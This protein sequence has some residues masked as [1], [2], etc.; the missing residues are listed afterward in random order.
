MLSR[1]AMSQSIDPHLDTRATH[2]VFEGIDPVSIDFS[3]PDPHFKS[4][5]HKLQ[6]SS[7]LTHPRPLLNRCALVL[8]LLLCTTATIPATA[9]DGGAW[10][11]SGSIALELRWFPEDPALPDQFEGTQPSAVLEPELRWR[12][13]DRRHQIDLAGFGRL[14]GRD[15][16]RSHLDLREASYRYIGDSFE[17]LA[18]VS[19]VFWGVTEARHLVDTLN[20]IDGVEDIDE[21]DRLGQ[22]MV[23]L[24]LQRDWGRLELFALP[25]FRERT[26]PGAEGR[27]RPPLPVAEEAR[28]GPGAGNERV[29]WALRWSHVLGDWDLG[30]HLFRGTGREPRLVPAA[31]GRRLI[32]F[33]EAI[34]QVG[35]DLQYTRGAWLWKLEALAR[36]G[37][38]S[39]FGAAVA[40]LERTFYQ[41]GGS[42]ADLGVLMEV[43]WDDRDASA[44]PTIFDRDT[45]VGARL[46]LN[47][48]QD[49]QLLVGAV[50][51]H[52]DGST[53][54]LLEAARRIG[55]RL[56][57]EL[58][59][60]LFPH[61]DP[62]GDLAAF[63]R[64]SFVN[65][66]VAW[67]W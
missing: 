53:F 9:Q 6:M 4:V 25:G 27:L 28:Y 31:D 48:I 20:Q 12:S 2:M 10:T 1:I 14:D 47:D 61:V 37:Q 66:R 57:L 44:P 29:D 38:G 54:A 18:G 13:T 16:Q 51:D 21:E 22:P 67:H 49:S 45:F 17:I 32:P 7:T 63:D 3:H 58:E 62:A 5:A 46:A 23:Q 24:A 11:A 60:R 33:Y 35:V 50:V 39:T 19:R 43:L 56:T 15:D 65:L 52:D 42:A 41:I 59:A 34:E 40:G 36:Q 64:D 8:I 55:R 30:V 26:F